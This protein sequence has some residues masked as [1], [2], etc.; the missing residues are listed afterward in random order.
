MRSDSVGEG[1]SDVMMPLA[2][3]SDVCTDLT[4]ASTSPNNQKLIKSPKTDDWIRSK[5]KIIKNNHE[6]NKYVSIS[7]LKT[8]HNTIAIIFIFVL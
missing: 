2:G 8:E 1:L 3:S 7:P 4:K 6:I 5:K